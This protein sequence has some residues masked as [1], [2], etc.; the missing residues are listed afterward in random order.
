MNWN[1]FPL[2]Y[3]KRLVL[4]EIEFSDANDIFAIYSDPRIAEFDSFSPVATISEA[5]DMICGYRRE[6]QEKRQIRWGIGERTADRLIGTCEFMNFNEASRQCEIG[7]GLV[8]SEWSKGYMKEALEAILRYGF[9]EM[10]LN[11]IEAF[12]V[13]GNCAS[14]CLFRK[15]GF[16][17][18]GVLRE[19]EYFKGR[20][21]NEIIMSMLRNDYILFLK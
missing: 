17:H 10:G 12:I 7:C 20:F 4:R 11:R 3:T 5:R 1:S 14:V 18:E 2:L 13:S 19:K 9:E 6:F 21:H 16:I 15:M 8:S